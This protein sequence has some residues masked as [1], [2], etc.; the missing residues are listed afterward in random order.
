M[1]FDRDTVATAL[2]GTGGAWLLGSAALHARSG[3]WNATQLR[4]L[5]YAGA[6]FLVSAAA[7]HLLRD[8]GPRGIGLSLAGTLLAMRGM[9]LLVRERAAT[10]AAR[11]DAGAPRPP[12]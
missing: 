11:R 8:A 2:V 7:A 4:G 5:V 6:G 1:D 9:Y 10:R 3:R 12:K